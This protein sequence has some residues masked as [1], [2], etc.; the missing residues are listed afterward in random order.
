MQRFTWLLILLLASK[1]YSQTNIPAVTNHGKKLIQKI[2]K[3]NQNLIK[4]NKS[5]YDGIR[6]KEDIYKYKK[7]LTYHYYTNLFIKHK[8]YKYFIPF[9]NIFLNQGQIRIKFDYINGEVKDNSF[10]FIIDSNKL[11]DE[12]IKS[13]LQ[14]TDLSHENGEARILYHNKNKQV[15]NND[16][17]LFIPARLVPFTYRSRSTGF[18]LCY[19]SLYI[20]ELDFNP[21]SEGEVKSNLGVS[22]GY[23]IRLKNRLTL[24]LDFNYS[25]R[26]FIT[27]QENYDP[28]NFDETY[29]LIEKESKREV[30]T[31]NSIFKYYCTPYFYIGIGP[32]FS[33]IKASNFI[34][35]FVYFNPDDETSSDNEIDSPEIDFTCNTIGIMASFGLMLFPYQKY[36]PIFEISPFYQIIISDTNYPYYTEGTGGLSSYFFGF[37]LKIGG[38]INF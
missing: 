21:S 26:A 5:G 23:E 2:D 31:L 27:Y 15:K 28:Y 35:S 7:M 38:S 4:V 16:L 22:L 34:I 8:Y 37:N 1:V 14:L 20:Y 3:L 30:F 24:N 12:D 9:G 19:N 29:K 13:Y 10:L 25:K 18:Y 11:P 17:F 36:H 6:I 32:L 33:F